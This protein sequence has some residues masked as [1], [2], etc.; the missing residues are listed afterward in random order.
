MNVTEKASLASGS[1]A[2]NVEERAGVARTLAPVTA[3]VP[4]PEGALVD[5]ANV[6]LIDENGG[7]QP[8]QTEALGRW[9]DGSIKWLLVDFQTDVKANANRTWALQFGGDVQPVVPG[10]RIEITQGEEV[11]LVDAETLRF[12]VPRQRRGG[13]SGPFRA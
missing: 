4:F 12:E 3:G 10:E 6:R 1:I 11:I 9:R 13:S 2:L 7:E 8:L 5:G